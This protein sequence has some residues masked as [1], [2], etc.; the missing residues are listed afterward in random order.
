MCKLCD[1]LELK[2]AKGELTQWLIQN[3][4]WELFN[5]KDEA[6]IMLKSYIKEHIPFLGFDDEYEK[7]SLKLSQSFRRQQRAFPTRTIIRNLFDFRPRD[8]AIKKEDDVE[9]FVENEIEKMGFLSSV[10]PEG[11]AMINRLIS[12]ITGISIAGY[13]IGGNEALK[14]IK[15]HFSSHKNSNIRDIA[16]SI[17]S[18]FE[19]TNKNVLTFLENYSAERVSQINNTTKQLLK[20]TIVEGYKK[21][22]GPQEIAKMITAQFQQFSTTRARVIAFTELSIGAGEAR[23]ESYVRRNIPFK[24]WI[25]RGPNPCPICLAN[26]AQGKIPMTES[27]SG[28]VVTVPQHPLCYSEDT[29]VYTENGWK[30]FKDLNNEKIYSLNPKTLNA[31]FI[32]YKKFVEYQFKGEM[33]HF[34]SRDV[35]LLVTPEHRMFVGKRSSN[36]DRK[37]INW[38]IESAKNI[39]GEI[40]LFRGQKYSEDNSLTK[41]NIG[42]KNYSSE[43]YGSFM[44]WYLSEGSITKRGKNWYQIFISQ[45]KKENRKVIENLLI[46]LGI[47][48]YKT[49]NGFGFSDILWGE[50]LIQFGK[51]SNKF[52]PKEVK[53]LD[54]KGLN[55]FID[56]YILGD[57]HIKKGKIFKNFKFSN[58]RSITTS[59]EKIADDL[60]ELFLKIGKTVSYKKINTKGNLQKFKNG[61]YYINNNTW[62]INE[63][64]TTKLGCKVKK[65]NIQ[66]SGKVYDVE[67]EKWHVLLVRRNGKILWSG[68]CM[69]DIIPQL[70]DFWCGGSDLSK[71]V[72]QGEDKCPGHTWYG[73]T[74]NE[75]T[76]N[77]PLPKTKSDMGKQARAINKFIR[78]AYKKAP[79]TKYFI[80]RIATNIS[81]K[82]KNS[83]VAKAPLKKEAKV[84]FN[85]ANKYNGDYNRISD[86]ARN[87]IVLNSQKDY[88]SAYK[89][90]RANQ[91]TTEIKRVSKNKDLLGYSGVNAK[92]IAPNRQLGEIQ[93]NT[94]DMIYA[95]E[96]KVDSYKILGKDLFSKMEEKY[97]GRGG[98]GHTYYDEW[99]KIR[100]NPEKD[101]ERLSL[102]KESKKYYDYFR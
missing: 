20:E 92:I 14:N 58:S 72:F 55:S 74:G 16:N 81:N 53:N 34:N 29:E 9:D 100:N 73:G 95:K 6:E 101:K 3:D 50:Y 64:K 25:T 80:D 32:E 43:L 38:K 71:S 37:K 44:G 61:S 47:K 42:N 69:C 89:I 85:I 88:G 98:K 21:G 102:E 12:V 56:A 36:S 45:Q 99:V 2:K 39:S 49:K 41:I 10:F 24:K 8:V 35:D 67:L 79:D 77:I 63:L 27:F 31:D 59:S 23:Y 97:K 11:K 19:L 83:I 90:L 94:V 52:I 66:Y 4:S 65:D 54:K 17:E 96:K 82:F 70:S 87:T 26:Q 93:I 84:R 40:H 51:S 5:A 13:N 60:C 30:L 62:I 33:I 28:G 68:N 7:G 46:S 78:D 75:K 18:S 48:F 91:Y 1:K 22:K 76:S 15:E 57:G 86:I